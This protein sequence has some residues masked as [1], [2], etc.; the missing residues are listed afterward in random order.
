MRR[1]PIDAAAAALP[2]WKA[3]PGIERGAYL[4]CLAD[5]MLRDEERLG[6]LMTTEQD[7][8]LGEA[9]GEIRYAAGFLSWSAEEATRIYGGD[10]PGVPSG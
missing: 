9:R 4:R 6:R 8:P 1:P 7:K 2:A 10:R 5:L 3:L